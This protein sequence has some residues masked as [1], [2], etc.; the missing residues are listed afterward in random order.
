ME[1]NFMEVEYNNILASSLGIYA[2]TLPSIPMAVQ[3][4]SSV[5][6]PGSDGTMHILDGGYESTEIKI[7]F[8]Y[9][10]P[11][12]KWDE[13]WGCAKKWLSA[14]NKMLRL[15]SDPD[16]FY[17]ILK[18]SADDA[19]HTSERIG[20]FTATFQTKDGLRYLLEEL[21]EHAAE[22]VSFNPYEISHP[23][24]KISGEGNCSLIVNGKKM[25][26]DVGQNLTIDTDRKIAYRADGTLS[27]TAVSGD[28]EDLFL[29]EG[30][31]EISITDG[32]NLKIIPNWR[33]L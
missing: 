12:D 18:V 20:N 3:K 32:F 14:R 27:N 5:E 31:N 30:E 15:G 25:S 2:K 26:A 4:E 19:E 16:H 9:I 21:N 6:I 29:Q 24:Y 28:Y 13:R 17:K 7:D 22:N 11:S 33:C 10:G 1:V 23:I 8:N